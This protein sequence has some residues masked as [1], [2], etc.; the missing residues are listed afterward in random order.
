[1]GNEQQKKFHLQD[2]VLRDFEELFARVRQRCPGTTRSQLCEAAIVTLLALPRS[3]V[4]AAIRARVSYTGDPTQSARGIIR[5]VAEL[6]QEDQ[7]D[8]AEARRAVKEVASKL[9]G[10]LSEK[11]PAPRRRRKGSRPTG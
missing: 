2:A 5:A 10:S 8:A 4:E 7:W 1:M 3:V 9:I 6:G 11:K